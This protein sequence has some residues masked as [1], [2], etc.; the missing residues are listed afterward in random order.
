MSN[1]IGKPDKA[2]FKHWFFEKN[3]IK[4]SRVNLKFAE[5]ENY[6]L[7]LHK[8]RPMQGHEQVNGENTSRS[9]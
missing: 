3:A 8:K 2:T 9:G 6:A 7:K 1:H 5:R 4:L